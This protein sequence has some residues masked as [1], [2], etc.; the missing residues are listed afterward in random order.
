MTACLV[1]PT[2]MDLSVETDPIL[3]DEV[4]WHLVDLAGF[5]L[6]SKKC[7]CK[8]N[9]LQDKHGQVQGNAAHC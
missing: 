5:T 4:I 9:E 6:A 7:K 1:P 2:S 8:L 3:W